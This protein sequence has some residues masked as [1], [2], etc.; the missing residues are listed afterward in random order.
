MIKK[1]DPSQ[2]PDELSRTRRPTFR[3]GEVCP[4][5]QG[6]NMG[7]PGTSQHPAD[8]HYYGE[9]MYEVV[10][11]TARD[12]MLHALQTGAYLK[13]QEVRGGLRA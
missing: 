12:R 13:R 6:E 1:H 7:P 8:G 10:W 9:H 4:G 11:E 2:C 3:P 5:L